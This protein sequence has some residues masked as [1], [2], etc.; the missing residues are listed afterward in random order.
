M[1]SSA[2]KHKKKATR[3]AGSTAGRV[4][5]R[6][7]QTTCIS[8]VGLLRPLVSA[9]RWLDPL[10]A[11]AVDYWCRELAPGRQRVRVGVRLYF[12]KEADALAVA[13]A[14]STSHDILGLGRMAIT[15]A[16]ARRD[17]LLY[18]MMT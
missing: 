11:Y 13:R 7:E 15:C 5:P 4:T 2:K 16:V 10:Q 8:D 12:S 17:W 18:R 14:A 6:Y 9:P 3:R 1:R